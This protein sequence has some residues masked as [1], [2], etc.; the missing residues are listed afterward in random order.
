MFDGAGAE[1]GRFSSAIF[2]NNSSSLS[3]ADVVGFAPAVLGLAG[4]SVVVIE[5]AGGG[6]GAGAGGAD[7]GAT[8]GVTATTGDIGFVE[9]GLGV[10]AS[11]SNASGLAGVGA[12]V[13]V[14]V[15]PPS[16]RFGEGVLLL[17]VA[18]VGVPS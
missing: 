3:N 13:A 7:E 10:H 15:A 8:G 12:A 14:V 5:G 18:D 16:R 11:S 9:L 4:G 17:L 1:G 2:C 6:A